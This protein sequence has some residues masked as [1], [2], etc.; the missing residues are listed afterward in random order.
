MDDLSPD[1]IDSVLECNEL[2]LDLSVNYQKE[3]LYQEWLTPLTQQAETLSELLTEPEDE[4]SDPS[5]PYEEIASRAGI[6]LSNLLAPFTDRRRAPGAMAGI[7]YCLRAIRASD[8]AATLQTRS[9][10]SCFPLRTPQGI[11]SC[12]CSG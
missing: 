6:A 7:P 11:C 10:P 2:L 1:C 8:G 3:Q 4:T 9:I 12:A 5:K